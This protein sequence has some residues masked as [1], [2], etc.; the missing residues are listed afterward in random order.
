MYSAGKFH[1]L[2]PKLYTYLV[3]ELEKYIYSIVVWVSSLCD[4]YT[5]FQQPSRSSN[6]VSND[7]CSCYYPSR[8]SVN[9]RNGNRSD[10][11]HKSENCPSFDPFI[12]L[13]IW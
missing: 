11:K 13:T 4:Q 7:C 1:L 10:V 8:I 6:D 12:N 5:K 2:L 9:L 3:C